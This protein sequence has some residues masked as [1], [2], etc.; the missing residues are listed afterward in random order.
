MD[1]KTAKNEFPPTGE[2]TIPIVVAKNRLDVPPAGAGLGAGSK[3]E[4][5]AAEIARLSTWATGECGSPI[6]AD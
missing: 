5:N 4:Q 2:E 1:T 3:D 6:L